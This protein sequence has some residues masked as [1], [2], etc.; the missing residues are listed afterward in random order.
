MQHLTNSSR[1]K[2]NETEIKTFVSTNIKKYRINFVCDTCKETFTRKLSLH[3]HIIRASCNK[4]KTHI[5][6]PN[7]VALPLQNQPIQP[8]NTVPNIEIPHQVN[9]INDNNHH[10]INHNENITNTNNN[11]TINNNNTIIQHI[12]PLGYERLP[13]I[14]QNEMRDLL[15]LGDKGV[16]AIIKLVCKQDENKNFYKL[17]MNKTN[18]SYLNDE[19]TVDI[20]QE[21][22]LKEKL[23][24]QCVMLTYQMLLACSS[25]MSNRDIDYVNSNL[26]NVSKSIKEEIYD[27]G[28]RNI[29]EFELRTNNK[30]TKNKIEKYTKEI[31]L[32]SNTEAQAKNKC[33]EIV[34]IKNTINKSL[35]PSMSLSEINKKLGNPLTNPDLEDETTFNDFNLNRFETTKYSK[36]WNKRLKD[37]K[38]LIMSI[39]NKTIGDI[40]NLENRRKEIEGKLEI[41]QETNNNMGKYNDQKELIITKDN[42]KVEIPMN[43]LANYRA[44]TYDYDVPNIDELGISSADASTRALVDISNEDDD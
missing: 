32:N 11:I 2:F 7:Q 12:Y 8:L 19:Y 6:Q 17:N 22:E 16:V 15:L 39:P 40:T 30:T 34:K 36:Y 35:K 18:I 24:K 41:M 21:S 14:P 23:L 10:N 31:S 42:F 9:T 4:V 38:K 20:C 37:E 43:Y 25:I 28:L 1:C 26:Q 3:R 33:R 13:N 44:L 27:N 5:H 29:I